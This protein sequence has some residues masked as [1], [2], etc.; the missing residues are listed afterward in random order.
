[1]EDAGDEGFAWQIG[2]WDQM[3]GIYQQ[4]IDTRFGPVTEHLLRRAKL[5]SA[6]TVLDLGTGTGSVAI[7]AAAKLGPDGRIIAVDIS[8]EMLDKAR[9]RI[10]AHSF[11]NVEFAEGRAEEIP[12]EDDSLDVVLASL[13]MM[14]VINRASAAREISRVLKP[15]GRFVASVWGG[16]DETDIVKF[17]Q[18]AG[19][20]APNPPVKGVGPG[21][22]S[23]PSPFLMQL[24]AVGLETRCEKET[25]YFQFANFKDAWD[26]LAGV[27]T[28]ALDPETQ[29]QAKAAV[30]DLMWLNE[31]SP[32]EFRNITHY[33]TAEKPH[34]DHKA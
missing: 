4:E 2:V 21:A 9:A 19:S 27:T 20:F 18:I 3:S 25:T 16:P 17:Q 13:S 32:R 14:Y 5:K 33:I 34:K 31:G 23:D 12:A 6:E 28:A 30:R 11:N 26:A 15:G 1:M 24:E 22:L 8:R 7:A 10:Q 29:E